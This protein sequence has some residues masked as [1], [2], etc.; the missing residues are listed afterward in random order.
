MRQRQSKNFFLFFC[1]TVS[2]GCR[3]F[4]V[5]IFVWLG[6]AGGQMMG[7]FTCYFAK[8]WCDSQIKSLSC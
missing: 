2:V 6:A 4:F 8:K 1:H 5:V 7:T 3:A